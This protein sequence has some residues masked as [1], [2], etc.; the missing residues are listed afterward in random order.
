MNPGATLA[1][2][3]TPELSTLLVAC[4]CAR[5]CNL[6]ESYRATFDAIAARHPQH[7]FIWVDIEDE[8]DLVHAVD[9][10]N[11]PTLLIASP[12]GRLRFLGVLTPQPETLERVLRAA[13]EG[14]L[15]TPAHELSE[16]DLQLLLGGL[17]VRV[18]MA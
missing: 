7:R 4:L 15:P 16:G 6:C 5:W 14:T 8:A 11:F 1:N 9:V 2:T 10:E 3:A 18:G 13:A 12:P 17:Q